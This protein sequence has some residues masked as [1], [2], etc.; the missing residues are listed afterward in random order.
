MNYSTLYQSFIKLYRA[1]P[2]PT[3]RTPHIY[4]R[5]SSLFI[6]NPK[7]PLPHGCVSVRLPH[8]QRRELRL[9]WKQVVGRS[10]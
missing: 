5:Y 4:T 9:L 7:E 6:V 10:S 2:S 3:N 1:T 8:Q